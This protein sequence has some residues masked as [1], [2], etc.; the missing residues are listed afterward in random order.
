MLS[1]YSFNPADSYI[2]NSISQIVLDTD[3]LA[4]KFI[5][6]I[7]YSLNVHKSKDYLYDT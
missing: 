7:I 3:I 5:L 4:T 2:N 1:D 6:T